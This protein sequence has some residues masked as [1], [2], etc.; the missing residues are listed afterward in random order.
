MIKNI[1]RPCEIRTHDSI[2]PPNNPLSVTSTNSAA[3]TSSFVLLEKNGNI[4]FYLYSILS[5]RTKQIAVL[6]LSINV[7]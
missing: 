1:Y 3:K 4:Y 7:F 2:T 6:V 5:Y